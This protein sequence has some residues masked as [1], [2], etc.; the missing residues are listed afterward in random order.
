MNEIPGAT[1]RELLLRKLPAAEAEQLENRLLEDGEMADR[2]ELEET[3]L[4]DD[5][6]RGLLSQQDRALVEKY[7]LATPT[8]GQRLAFATALSQLTNTGPTLATE[9]PRQFFSFFRSPVFAFGLAACLLAL[10]GTAVHFWRVRRSNAVTSTTPVATDKPS[11]PPSVA[12]PSAVPSPTAAP[13]T[14]ALL[15]ANA[16]GPQ[17]PS[18][19]LPSTV[20][21]LR[22]QCEVPKTDP[23]ARFRM[24]LENAYRGIIGSED[25][26][27]TRESAG[28][29]YVE[30]TFPA[31]KM[32][33]GQYSVYVFSQADPSSPL[34]SYT[35]ALQAE[36]PK[37]GQ[38]EP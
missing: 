6:A 34:Q 12:Q 31:N 33:S 24:V 35:F 23:T 8:S 38:L 15:V 13:F 4:L 37:S 19:A 11:P 32:S 28:I 26:L 10:F 16:R 25:Q 18:F 30:I 5:Y 3:D 17:I 21:L 14:I 1:L 7:L 9:K 22:V 2:L 20:R 27:S 36:K 29:H